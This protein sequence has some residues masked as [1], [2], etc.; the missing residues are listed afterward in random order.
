MK[1]AVRGVLIA[2]AAVAGVA[3]ILVGAWL[4]L[5]RMSF[6][7]VRGTQKLEGL[8][9]PVT[10]QRDRYGVPH[11]YARTSKDLFFAEGYVHAQDRFWQ[12]EFCR[13]IGEGRLSELF[14]KSQLQTDIFLRTL[15]IA[16]V[17]KQEYE[18]AD[19]ATKSY[20][21]AY[22]AGVNAYI[23]KRSPARLGLEFAV[24]N[25]TGVKTKIE[26]WTPVNTLEWAKMMAWNGEDSWGNE[27]MMT[28][29]LHTLGTR[30]IRGL[31]TPYRKEM[32]FAASDEERGVAGA[33]ARA[34]LALFGG[35]GGFGS[36]AWAV[37]GSRS[38]S[39]K[40]VLAN[41][42]HLDVQMPAVWYEIGLHGIDEQGR[43][44]RTPDCPFD[45]Y[46]YSL[47]GVPGVITGH[48]DRI[49]WGFTFTHGDTQ[50]LYLERINP[51]NPDQYLV[52]GKWVDMGIVY[53]SI[54][55]RKAKEPYRLRVRTT[56]HGP[57]ISDHG[58][59]TELEG[60][61]SSANAAFPQD[62]DLTAVSLKWTPLQA[63][64]SVKAALS[65][66]RAENYVQ[67][68]EAASNWTA[69]S[70]NVVYADVDGNI[71]YQFMGK[72][73]IRRTSE[74]EAP[75]P[76]WSS[77]FDWKGYIPFDELPHSLN[78]SKGYVV[79]ANNPPVGPSYPYLLGKELDYG[80]RARRIVEMIHSYKDPIGLDE[81]QKMQADTQN[82]TALE[83]CAALKGLD[84]H[85]TALER[86]ITE[87]KNKDLTERRKQ[88]FEKKQVE[89][90]ERMQTA[91][92]MLLEWDGVMSG[93]SAAAA[94]YAYVWQQLV[95]EVFRDQFPD[96]EWPMSTGTR[97][98]NAVHY[99]LQEPNA[100]LWDDITTPERE[101]RDEI[102]IRSFRR[103]YTYYVEEAGKNPKKWRWDKIHTI[104]FKNQ[105]LGKS[106]IG[107]IEKIF[108]RGPYPLGGGTS[109]VNAQAWDRKKPFEVNHYPS[110]RFIIDMAD[111]GG[112]L[113]IL[114][115]GES[116]HPTNRHYDD[117]IKRWR[118]VEYHPALWNQ[119]D[120]ERAHGPKL[121]L[122][123][124]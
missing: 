85:P 78:P 56:R 29:V 16:R 75:M 54:P 79:S 81:F 94:L 108:N 38:K 41:D 28:R 35:E 21:N 25:L 51:E 76:G 71:A 77:Q 80:Y 105:T 3:I 53:E 98:E 103:G 84:L 68:R 33:D 120:I 10:I 99:L 124:R 122:V 8:S 30:G 59:Q 97:A 52:D 74:G 40:P 44:G 107:P 109:E 67:F 83:I 34:T 106:G 73:P 32:P 17:A 58:D 96:K 118:D 101:T 5:T 63:S 92:Q 64:S 46:G 18:Q 39:G 7:R 2:L 11:I 88:D 37:A 61:L 1:K 15:G 87:E 95:T 104:T 55:V 119:S 47:P 117:F 102:L 49:A 82:F 100:E 62:I 19:P 27:V 93:E 121:T 12:M 66:N 6:P 43:A 42:M 4:V 36:N 90:L 89:A 22:A 112:A 110:M 111:L 45:L 65:L 123:P 60:F 48:N 24:L 13:R 14:G 69:P 70:L 72:I 91:R 20:L 31:F 57:I 23:S 115:T 86:R 9:A 50:D 116:G 26:P 113:G 114:P